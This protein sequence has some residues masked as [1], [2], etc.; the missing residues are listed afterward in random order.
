MGMSDFQELAAEITE[1]VGVDNVELL[2]DIDMAMNTDEPMSY[3]LDI[4][5]AK[6]KELAA[7]S[8]VD[9]KC[10]LHIWLSFMKSSTV[11]QTDL[12]CGSAR[13]ASFRVLIIFLPQ[14]GRYAGNICRFTTSAQKYG[15]FP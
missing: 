2:K 6:A 5:H 4:P 14:S 10:F 7:S 9:E 13:E 1:R 11:R 3:Y 8:G 12:K 15:T